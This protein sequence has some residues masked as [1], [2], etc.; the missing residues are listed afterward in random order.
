MSYKFLYHPQCLKKLR[1]IPR[2]DQSRILKKLQELSSNPYTKSLDTKKLIKTQNN[3]RLRIGNLRAIYEIGEKE[4]T[5][6]VWE[7]D[8]RGNIY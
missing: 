6:F 4:K 7:I 3:Y 5:I 8:Y 2:I 1:K